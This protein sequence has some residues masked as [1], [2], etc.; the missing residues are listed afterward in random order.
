MT[1]SP[2]LYIIYLFY[3]LPTDSFL[4]LSGLRYDVVRL[5]YCG[6]VHVIVI[7]PMK[8]M[9][10]HSKQICSFNPWNTEL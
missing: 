1:C 3:V 8:S 4:V 7:K 10:N 9:L 2:T 5:K 6:T